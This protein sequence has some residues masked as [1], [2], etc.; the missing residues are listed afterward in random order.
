MLPL[1]L[2]REVSAFCTVFDSFVLEIALHKRILPLK[3]YKKRL[4]IEPYEYNY[5]INGRLVNIFTYVSN[6]VVH[7]RVLGVLTSFTMVHKTKLSTRAA[8]CQAHKALD[9]QSRCLS[10]RLEMVYGL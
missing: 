9:L 2:L 8:N 1:D 7:S 3:V 10:R 6:N 5:N 4:Y